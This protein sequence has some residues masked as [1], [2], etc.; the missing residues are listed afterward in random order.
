MVG[1]LELWAGFSSSQEITRILWNPKIHYRIH[2]C[3]PPV[4]IPSHL[5]PV[6][7]PTFH[8]LKIHLNIIPHLRLGLPSFL[9]PSFSPTKSLYTPLLSPI[10]A[11]CPA[12]L[13]LLDFITRKI[14]DEG[15][16]SLSYPLCCVLNIPCYL[17]PFRPKYSQHPILKHP[18]PTFLPQYERPIF[19]PIQGN[20]QNYSSVYL[21]L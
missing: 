7:S 18:Q 5:D 15:Y 4:P 12:N 10:R 16:T 17:A 21:N 8:F 9:F 6:H 11:T 3:P 1:F 19:T 13:I 2:K 20:R 14:L